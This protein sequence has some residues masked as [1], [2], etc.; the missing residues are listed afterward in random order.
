MNQFFKNVIVTLL[1][2]LL[3]LSAMAQK[4]TTHAVKRGETLESITKKYNVTAKSILE[5]NKEIK[6]GQNLKLNTILVIPLDAKPQTTRTEPKVNISTTSTPKAEEQEVPIGFRQHKVRKKETLYSIAKLYKIT[7]NDIKRYNRSLYASQLQR[8][9]VLKIPKYKRVAPVDIDVTDEQDL[10]TYIVASKETRW[11]IAHKY[12]ITINEMETLNPSLEKNTDYLAEGF[13]LKMPKKNSGSIDGQ[14]TQ[15]YTS[16]VVPKGIGIF[17]VTQEFNVT[18]KEVMDLNPEIS[19]NGG[20]KE[21][22]TLRL[23]EKKL[24]TGEVNTDNYIFYEVK[25]K[26]NEF[27]LTRKFGMSW[28]D[29]VALNPDLKQGVKAGMV[30]KLPK[31][32][33]GDFEVKNAL[34]LDKINLLDSIN[35]SNTPK[36]LFLLP[37]RLD[38]VDLKNKEDAE[39]AIQ[40]STLT[41]I[42]LGLYSGALIAVDSLAKLGV[43]VDVKTF[44]NEFSLV[45]TKEILEMENLSNISAVIG[46]LD[47]PSLREVAVI[48]NEYNVP[49][50]APTR[51]D[52]DVSLKNVFFPFTSKAVLRET[53][54]KYLLE[55]RT[56]ENIVVIADFKGIDGKEAILAKFPEAKI[57]AVKEEKKNIG[58]NRD[59]LGALFSKEKENWVFVE[60]DNEKLISSL[61]S[62][63]NSFHNSPIGPQT[64]KE[65]IVVK[66]YTTDKNKA[67][68]NDVISGAH[69]SKLNFTYP[70]VYRE[71]NNNTS[72]VREYRKRFGDAPDKYAVRGFD[73]TY[74]ILLK[75]AYKNNLIEASKLIGQTEYTGNKFSYE[76]DYTSG[77][78][79]QAS[80][81][82]MYD[83]MRIKQVQ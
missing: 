24:T 58:I 12:G 55:K 19:K 27:R 59:K 47:V 21:G 22:M 83:E 37:F 42:S 57:A 44:D 67:F 40:R 71:V 43:S 38:R 25:P 15:L 68:D 41:K 18:A 75:L 45:K 11:S 32:Q 7:E 63:L 76:K 53:M 54:L 48:S 73:M 64:S 28:R 66:M 82:M 50:V 33:T 3:G 20:L 5:L 16:Y 52:T 29:I 30:L 80:Y 23:P 17:R 39:E 56:D 74:D 8:K 14:K 4:F 1:F 65:K 81:I 46:P 79:N 35:V 13:Q 61:T 36:L 72:F 34:A 77:F 69:L 26:Q 10:E 51:A 31:N 70:S 62:I 60:S 2:S 9:M 78:F 49:V 6:Q